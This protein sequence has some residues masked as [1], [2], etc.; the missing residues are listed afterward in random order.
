MV[1]N[2]KHDFCDRHPVLYQAALSQAAQAG[3]SMMAKVL[4]HTR[5]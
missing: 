3:E 2:P 5:L 4:A 1:T